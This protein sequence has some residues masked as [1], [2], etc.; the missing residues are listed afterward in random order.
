MVGTSLNAGFV[1][2][3]STVHVQTKV[4]EPITMSSNENQVKLLYKSVLL[5]CFNLT[6]HIFACSVVKYAKL[7]INMQQQQI[8]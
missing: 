2:D 6:L 5:I 3:S 7:E 8:K 4:F 1:S